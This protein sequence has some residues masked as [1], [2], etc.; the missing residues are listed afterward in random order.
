VD[1]RA[2][3]PHHPIPEGRLVDPLLDDPRGMHLLDRRE[4][5]PEG[6]FRHLPI[7]LSRMTRRS[8]VPLGNGSSVRAGH[9]T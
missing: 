2:I 7:L 4:L 3:S 9:V 6:Q 5:V 8:T 1:N